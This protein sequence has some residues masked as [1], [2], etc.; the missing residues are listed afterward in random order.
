MR[1]IAY[2]RVSGAGQLDGYGPD[3]QLVD[4]QRYAER[5][6]VEI[7]HT[8]VESYTGTAEERPEFAT[9]L[10]LVEAGEAD[11]I[12]VARFDRLARKLTVQEALLAL[13]W[14]AGGVVHAADTG[15]ILHD[16]PDDPMRTAMR[17]MAGVFAELDR[18]MIVARL[19][20]GREAKRK[21][22]GYAGGSVP[23]GH[24][25][26]DGQLVLD[27]E[28]MFI[29]RYILEDYVRTQ[30]FTHTAF[31]ATGLGFRTKNGGRWSARQVQRIIERFGQ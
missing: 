10:G 7:S 30:N 20:K 17:Q 9:A 2:V 12:L 1:L 25:V 24:K 15:E 16:D 18:S 31:N 27:E 3:V 22:G 13:V 28:E 5:A 8:L 21:N 29:V 11:G 4:I 23:F 26:Q 19:R 6:G 14:K